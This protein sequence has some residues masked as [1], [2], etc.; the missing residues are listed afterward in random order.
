M[1]KLAEEN[2]EAIEV[3]IAEFEARI[4]NISDYFY[5]EEDYDYSLLKIEVQNLTEII[6][7][8]EAL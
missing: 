7:E 2:S 3:L 4:S 1:V 6:E 5:E 8:I